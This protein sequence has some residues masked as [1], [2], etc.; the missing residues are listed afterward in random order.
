M[1]KN[2][3]TLKKQIIYRCSYTGTKETDILFKKKILIKLNQLNLSELQDLSNLFKTI[4]DYEISLILTRKIL[5]Q[6]KYEILF[7]ILIDDRS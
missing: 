1:E 7:N 6:K 2:I 5:P 4:S 3:N